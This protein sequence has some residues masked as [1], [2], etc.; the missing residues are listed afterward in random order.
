MLPNID[1]KKRLIK[2]KKV[3]YMEA[4]AKKLVETAYKN[5]L[6]AQSPRQPRFPHDITM[7]T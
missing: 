2:K 4:E 1:P 6:H 7:D 3:A 5:P